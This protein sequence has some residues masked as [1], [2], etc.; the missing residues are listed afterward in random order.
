[1][2][3]G[4]A[5]PY[6]ML[7][8][9]LPALGPL[10]GSQAPAITATRLEER[11][12]YLDPRD[13]AD[14]DALRAG[15][16]WS[17]LALGEDDGT[18][19]ARMDAAIARLRSPILRDAVRDR[20]ELRTLAAALRRRAAGQEAPPAGERWGY[21]RFVEVIR[22]NWA[23]PDFGVGRSFPW[24]AKARE[25]LEAGDS[26]GLERILLKAAWDAAARY[27]DGHVF[28]FEAV[29]F[30]VVRWSLVDRWARYDVAAATTRFSE[31]LDAATA[32]VAFPIG[33]NP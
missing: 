13:R 27:A 22:A 10:L 30:Y 6:I 20:L 33:T 18:F 9:S 7:M 19:L 3:G 32:D 24:L 26:A 25:R 16:S 21:G 2:M 5:E 12:G 11:L 29:A 31:L 14:L 28:D 15:L 4:T 8:A 23:Q 17:R 1:M